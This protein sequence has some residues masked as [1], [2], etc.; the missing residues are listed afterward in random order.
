MMNGFHQQYENLENGPHTWKKLLLQSIR[1]I[2]SDMFEPT[3]IKEMY[4]QI[5]Q[6]AMR[7]DTIPRT[8]V[9]LD[10][11]AVRVIY[12]VRQET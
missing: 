2:H 7:R 1:D 9:A 3:T 10:S 12:M 6:A 4:A 11:G 5:H 8:D